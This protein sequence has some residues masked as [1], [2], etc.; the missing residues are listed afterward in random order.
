MAKILNFNIGM[1]GHVDS[2]KTSLAKA[3]STVA[4]TAAFDKNPQSKERGITLDLG[5]SSFTV[6]VP[7]HLKGSGYEKV[8]YALVDCPGHASLIKTIIGGAQIIDLMVLVIDI[9]KGVQTQTA[10]CLVIGEIICN[11]MLVVLNKVDMLPPEK[12]QAAIEKMTKRM[13]K[14]L[15]NT[16]FA[17]CPITIAAANP[18]GSSDATTHREPQGIENLIQ[19]L[20]ESTYIPTRSANGS[21]LF[22]V[23]HCFSIR[24]QGTVMTGTVLSGK[25]SVNDQVEISSLQMTKKVKSIQMFRKPVYAIKQGDRAGL[26]VTQFD[27][28]LLER[29]LVCT[30]GSLP[31]LYAAVVSIAKIP[32]YSGS[33]ATK[34][35]FHVTIGHSTVMAQITIFAQVTTSGENKER[36]HPPGDA[37]ERL[38][39]QSKTF[40]FTADYIFRAEL[41]KDKTEKQWALLVFDKPVVCRPNSLAIGSKFDTDI[42]ANKCRLAFKAEI[43]EAI[44]AKDYVSSVLPKLKVYKNK[45]RE[46]TVERVHDD[47]SVICKGLLK[48]ET[49]IALFSGLRVELSTGESGVI[50]GSFGLSGKIKIRLPDGLKPET[51]VL[52]GGKGKKSKK[53]Q[54]ETTE[55]QQATTNQAV[56][57]AMH[58]KRYIYDPA[59]RMAQT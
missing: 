20:G 49:N 7:D 14:T 31:T 29:G 2:G 6:D 16:K 1:L 32:Y 22:S 17:G 27:P 55:P 57:V 24:G 53:K 19:V 44:T 25:A 41:S 56:R 51:K 54:N 12:K 37:M 36:N 26:C 34:S 35:K 39:L 40:D 48:K 4:S 52:L 11:K 38:T 30:P 59:K 21:F 46:G 10:E 45:S 33:V 8:Q 5:F 3:L 43:L 50:D 18:G 28:K 15:E 23:D 58:F 47:Y 9:V 13:Q 42:N